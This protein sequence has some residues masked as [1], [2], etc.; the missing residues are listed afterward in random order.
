MKRS[1]MPTA[2][3]NLGKQKFYPVLTDSKD[4]TKDYFGIEGI[5]KIA[6]CITGVSGILLTI[7]T[8]YYSNNR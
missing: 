4:K 3:I 5:S 2:G 8:F 1:G 7:I 6:F